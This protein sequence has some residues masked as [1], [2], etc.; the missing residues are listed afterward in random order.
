MTLKEYLKSIDSYFKNNEREYEAIKLLLIEKY[1]HSVANFYLS[2]DEEINEELIFDCNK[3]LNDF[4]PVQYILGYQYFYNLKIGVNN[5]V[6][7]PRYDTE[8]LVEKAIEYIKKYNYKKVLDICTGSG[9]IA[10]AIKKNTE[11][12]VVGSDISKE[13]LEVAI[14]NSNDLNMDVRFI[15]S[16]ILENIE[17]DCDLIV[18]NPPYISYNEH[19]DELVLKNEPHLALFADNEGLVFYERI[20]KES[21]EK[22]KNLKMIIFEIGYMQAKSL[23]ALQEKYYLLGV[24][25]VIKDYS[26]KDRVVIIKL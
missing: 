8:V 21:K 23:K 1:Y 24:F 17:Y 13:A 14:K 2:M 16:D 7:I 18:S 3:Y 20:L 4:I 10:L 5:N 25:E 6:L 9:A 26:G 22:N 11:C 19:V 15:Q 12:D